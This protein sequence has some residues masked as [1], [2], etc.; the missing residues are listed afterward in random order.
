[1]ATPATRRS[2]DATLGAVVAHPIRCLALS[3]LGEREASPS[4]IAREC[5]LEVSKVGYHVTALVEAGLIEEV[6]HRQVRGAVEHFYRAIVRTHI[7]SEE[8]EQLSIEERKSF[9]RTIWSMVTANA[10]TALESG[11]MVERPE[12]HLTRVPVRLDEQ[13]WA[14]LAEAYQGLLDRIFEI[15]AES[16]ER[17]GPQHDDPGIPVVAFQ[18]LFE[19]PPERNVSYENCFPNARPK[20]TDEE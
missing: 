11:S 6:R 1:L 20:D 5:G 12:H 14:D 2:P 8:E 4:E 15:H 19:M 3:I 7:D 16:A 18:A 17:L 9:A 13:G 10:S